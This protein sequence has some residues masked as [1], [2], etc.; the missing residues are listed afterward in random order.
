MSTSLFE[1]NAVNYLLSFEEGSFEFIAD[2]EA[3]S[4]DPSLEGWDYAVESAHINRLLSEGTLPGDSALAVVFLNLDQTTLGDSAEIVADYDLRAE[5]ALTGAPGPM[6]GNAQ[7]LLRIGEAGYWQ[8]YR[9]V[10][11]RTEE[12]STWSDLKSLVQ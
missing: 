7:F 9:W 2:P 10:D 1:R 6:A 12:A 8:I 5:V 4:Q 3:L 11:R